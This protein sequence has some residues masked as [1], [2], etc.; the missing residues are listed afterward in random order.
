MKK[1]LLLM[2][3]LL[4]Q[5]LL[6][7]DYSEGRDF[8]LNLRNGYTN[9]GQ[10]N[11][12]EYLNGY[13]DNPR[14]SHLDT[15]HLKD[16]GERV[17]PQSEAYQEVKDID[18]KKEKEQVLSESSN[19]IETIEHAEESVNGSQIPCANGECLPTHDENGTDFAEGVVRLGVV[20]KTAEEVGS[21]QIHENEP[22]L[23]AGQNLQCRI[24]ALHTGNC[25]GGHARFLNCSQEEK[26]LA[27]AILENRAA[28]VGRYCAK[29]RL[30]VCL[31]EKE[32][33]CVFPS[34]LGGV[35]Q[36][37]GRRSQL[38]IDFGWANHTTNAPN[39]RGITP[40]ELEHI[41][42]DRLNLS[43]FA[44]E[45]QGRRQEKDPQ[46][47]RSLAREKIRAEFDSRYGHG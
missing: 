6:A 16:M 45:L 25:C 31:E 43:A 37:Q 17:L 30:R 7:N 8:A 22:R 32:S 20:A 41:Q 27:V 40:I 15:Q 29:R 2:I 35:I 10:I 39:C 4:P 44:N 21:Q 19:H 12:N 42:F 9:S 3:F 5:V 47:L 28:Q 13:T 23:F 11:P 36:L 18:N 34:T 1:V 46:K 26:N 24:A 33:W 38:G 14:E